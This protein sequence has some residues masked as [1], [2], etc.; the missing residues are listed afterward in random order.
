[1]F[2]FIIRADQSSSELNQLAR[3]FLG[4]VSGQVRIETG[5]QARRGLG[6]TRDCITTA[7]HGQ[8]AAAL[9][10]FLLSFSLFYFWHHESEGAGL[11]ACA[12]EQGSKEPG[13]KVSGVEL[14]D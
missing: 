2:S 14:I 5:R 8:S 4:L 9:F 7:Q 6:E 11:G 3:R 1:L 10:L 13:A 12:A